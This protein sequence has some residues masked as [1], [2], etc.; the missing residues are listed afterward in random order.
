MTRLLLAAA[1]LV[2][3]LVLAMATMDG[4][5]TPAGVGGWDRQRQGGGRTAFECLE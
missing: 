4:E 3:V 1:A 2:A 5:R